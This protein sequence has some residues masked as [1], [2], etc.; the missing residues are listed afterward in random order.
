[1]YRIKKIKV[2]SLA[3]TLA[4]IN[5]VIGFLLAL[6]F[7]VIK[8]NSRLITIIDPALADTTY[9]QILIIYPISYAVGGFITGLALSFLYN[10]S[11]K[12]T[13]GVAVELKNDNTGKKR[14]K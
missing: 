10:L 12:L 5:L 8:I 14:K 7:I 6:L 11:T 4:L 2:L 9:I 1:M 13:N 3:Y